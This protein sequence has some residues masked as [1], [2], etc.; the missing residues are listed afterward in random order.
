[1]FHHIDFY[2]RT[3]FWDTKP[4]WPTV[5]VWAAGPVTA[6]LRKCLVLLFSLPAFSDHFDLAFWTTMSH[7]P[8][9]QN[10]RKQ[11]SDSHIVFQT[12]WSMIFLRGGG[13]DRWGQRGRVLQRGKWGLTPKSSPKSTRMSPV[14]RIISRGLID[15]DQVL[16]VQSSTEL[17]REWPAGLRFWF[18][19]CSLT[20]NLWFH[21]WHSSFMKD[22]VRLYFI[23]H[24][25]HRR[26]Y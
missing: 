14:C 9:T 16:D 24:L 21:F 13:Q 12:K 19:I 2:L 7:S 18:P 3:K 8:S 5:L 22:E 15:L 23:K 6:S 26:Y 10:Q 1:M 11:T 4:T 25:T 17:L 20:L